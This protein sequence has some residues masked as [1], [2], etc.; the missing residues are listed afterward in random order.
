M[1]DYL[2]ALRAP[3][4]SGSLMPVILAAAWAGVH[5]SF[6]WT[7]FVL[8]LIGVGCLH[9]GANLINDWADSR[10]SDPINERH[11]PFSG[12][13]RV[14]PEGRL[15]R[16]TVLLM[17]LVFYA[18]ALAIGV[19]MIKSYP[20]VGVLGGLGLVIGFGYSVHPWSFMS[21]G[22]GELGI[23]FAFGP[24]VT[25]GTYYVMTGELTWPAFLLGFPLGFLITAV[26]WINQFPDYQADRTAGKRNLVVRLGLNSARWVYSVLMLGSFVALI[27]LVAVGLPPL[28]LIGLGALPL[29]LKA[30]RV[31]GRHYADHPQIVPAQALTIQTQ[32]VMGAL[33][34]LGLFLTAFLG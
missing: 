34:S 17:S 20:L 12:G 31:F 22:L 8:T 21:R 3:F 27:G 28:L 30:C 13:S 15:S 29:A 9:L 7:P 25:L 32:L 18:A 16:R 10:G 5:E 26:I 14:I 19:Y 33:T 11:T 24:L 2:R 4:L 23:F 1:L 6:A